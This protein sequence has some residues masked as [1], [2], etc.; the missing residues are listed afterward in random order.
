[1]L[2]STTNLLLARNFRVTKGLVPKKLQPVW[3]IASDGKCML[4]ERCRTVGD[5]LLQSA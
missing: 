3:D 2:P 4:V 1:M 5:A